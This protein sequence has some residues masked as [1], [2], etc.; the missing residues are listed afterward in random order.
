MKKIIKISKSELKKLYEKEKLS[1]VKTAKIF[2]CSRN[3]IYRRLKKYRL[4]IRGKNYPKP[5]TK[6][7][8]I[9]LYIKQRLPSTAIAKRYKCDAVTV[10]TRLKEY[11]IKLRNNS[12]AHIRT[13][14]YDFNGDLKEKAYMIGFR[15]GDL[16]VRKFEKNGKIINV[17][18]GS[19]KKEQIKLIK[20]LFCKYCNIAISKPDQKGN[21]QINANLNDSFNFLLKKED[22]IENWILK[23]R[24][25][26]FAFLAG[27]TDA[28]GSPKIH[29]Q[30]FA[31]FSLSTYD[32]NI[33]HQIKD[34]LSTFGFDNMKLYLAIKKGAKRIKDGKAYLNKK[35]CWTLSIYKK[36]ELLKLYKEI[37]PYIKHKNKEKA[38]F[39]GIINID[40]RNRRYGYLRMKGG[41]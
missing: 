1:I 23:D 28:E 38:I 18:C 37:L 12:E 9:R 31:T 20:D 36:S 22:N 15:L 2:N 6:E 4:K 13:P 41:L 3:T 27:Y 40:K 21:I 26:F 30:G 17:S 5:I 32:K 39:K 29:K 25:A 24:K 16:H 35:D 8:L 19:S 34:R 11:G 10:L 14:K 7:E 33:L